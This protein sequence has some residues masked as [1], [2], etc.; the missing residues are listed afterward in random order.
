VPSDVIKG[1]DNTII[2]D[3]RSPNK[4]VMGGIVEY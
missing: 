1:K 3:R 2:D 4:K